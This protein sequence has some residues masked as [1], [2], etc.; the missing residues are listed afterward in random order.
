MKRPAL[1]FLF[2]SA[3][4]LIAQNPVA[5]PIDKEPA[6]HLVFENENIRMFDV[7]V[8]PNSATLMHRHETD[9]V[10][11]VLGSAKVS[12]ERAGAE[13][14]VMDLAEGDVRYVR[15]GFEHIARNVID[16]PFHNITIELKNPGAAVC[17]IESTPV[18]S[19]PM[20]IS[21]EHLNIRL[22]QLQPGEQTSVHT[23]SFPHLAIAVDDLAFENHPT[24]KPTNRFSM[25]KGDFIWISDTGITHS[26][27]NV[28]S[29]SA[30]L[31]SL[32]FK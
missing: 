17:G 3:A 21:T 2:F 24:G 32:E 1:L 28:G 29:Q 27:K 26:L 10:F 22:T 12:N 8:M 9:Y 7:T 20:L 6:H 5:V 11:V 16:T 23:H 14:R 4:V 15:G 18:C 19:A 30:R 13:P 31:L 25:K